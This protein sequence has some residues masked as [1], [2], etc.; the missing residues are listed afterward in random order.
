MKVMRKTFYYLLGILIIA[1]TIYSCKKHVIP[2]APQQPPPEEHP[3]PAPIVKLEETEPPVL[4]AIVDSISENV[5]VYYE[6]L[7][8]RYSESKENYPTIIDFHGGG[9][10]GDGNEDLHNILKLGIPKLISQ[11]L[12]PPS[13]TVNDE[14]F[15]FIVI[16]PQLAKKVANVE[17]LNI[18]DY[19]LEKYRVDTTRLYITG[20]SLG[21]RQASNYASLRPEKFAAMVTFAGLPQIDDDL[22]TKCQTMVDARLP[23]WHFHNRDDSAWAYSE[24]EEY[25]RVFNSLSP[26]IPARFTTFDVGQGKSHHDCWTRTVDPAYKEDGKKI[27]E[28]MLGYKRE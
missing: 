4:T 14:K 26:A 12:L 20:F 21:G 25:I 7:P 2:S 3:E 6:S 19:V 13:F 18:I 22:Q 11:Q 8:A 23:V 16:A 17:V 24:A 1:G 9:Q 27:Y 28:W 5:H 15:S 10:Y